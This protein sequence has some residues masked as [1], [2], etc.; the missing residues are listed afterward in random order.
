MWKKVAKWTLLVLLL[1]YVSGITL[2]ARSEAKSHTCTAI[3]VDIDASRGIADSVA[4]RGLRSELDRFPKKIIGAQL[5]TINTLEIE[6]YLSKFNNF[7]NIQCILTPERKLKVKA[8]PLIPELRVFEPGGVSYYI[9][10]DGKRIDAN[11]KFFV[12]VPVVQGR[13]GKDF[14]PTALL[15]VVRF[16]NSDPKLQLLISSVKAEDADNI[17]LIP[18]LGGHVIN[19][20]DTTLL[21]EKRQG[22]MTAYMSILPKMGWQTYDTVSVKFRNQVVCTRRDRGRRPDYA[23]STD[24]TD[25]EEATLEGLEEGGTAHLNVAH[26][27]DI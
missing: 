1:A 12:D 9:N 2:W 4:A 23:G 19:I 3:E 21:A 20:G 16:I 25:M 13:F 17:L 6:R 7:E 8:V 22:I 5:S 11:A 14:S 24:E 18:K 26:S 15:P 10:K 27:A